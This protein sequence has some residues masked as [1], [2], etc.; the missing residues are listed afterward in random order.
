MP[1]LKDL[2]G[3]VAT[4]SVKME[5]ADL[6]IMR[7]DPDRNAIA[8][9]FGDNFDRRIGDGDWQSPSIVMFDRGY[10]CIGIPDVSEGK[11][12]ILAG[13]R[14]EQLWDYPH[15]NSDYSTILPCDFIR[16]RDTWYVACMVTQGLGNEKRTV[17]WQSKDLVDWEKTSPYIRLDHRDERGNEIGHPGNT[18]LSF[19]Q[20]GDYVYIVGTNGLRRDR[21][22]YLWRCLSSQFPYGQWEPYG[23]NSI[24]GGWNWGVANERVPFIA[25]KFGELCLRNVQG[26]FVLSYFDSGNYRM[27]VRVAVNVEKLAFQ[28]EQIYAT[29]TMWGRETPTQIAQLYGGYISPLSELNYNGGMKFIVS[30][31]NTID[32]S[33]WPY[34]CIVMSETVESDGPIAPPVEPEPEEPEEEMTQQEFIQKLLAELGASADVKIKTPEGKELTL[35]EAIE[36]IHWKERT[37]LDL[38]DRPRD[39]QDED[40][41]FG[42]VLSMRAEMQILQALVYQMADQQLGVEKTKQIVAGVKASFK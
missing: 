29:G 30:Q 42:H 38:V 18:M 17:F 5:A 31:W 20:F 9:M 39:Y 13:Y 32:G 2:T 7:W 27:A 41:Q 33:N 28:T 26:Q 36:E 24:N 25:G 10:T 19:D 6:G 14:R 3:P 1:R 21:G 22:I 40:D 12:R 35:R 15:N 23:Y 8:A 11:P 37:Q 4:T 34:R 16:I